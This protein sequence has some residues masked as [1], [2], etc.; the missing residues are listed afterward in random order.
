[1]GVLDRWRRDR[2]DEE[3][4]NLAVKIAEQLAPALSERLGNGSVVVIGSL[5]L[6]LKLNYASGGGAT[7]NVVQR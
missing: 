3:A 5:T 6:N 2:E 1:M 7:V 4:R